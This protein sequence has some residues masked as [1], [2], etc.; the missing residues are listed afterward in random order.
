MWANVLGVLVGALLAL[1]LFGSVLRL[2]WRVAISSPPTETLPQRAR[3]QPFGALPG[4]GSVG[5]LGL[6][7][8]DSGLTGD[9][10]SELLGPGS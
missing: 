7:H 1:L 3:H 6:L 8:P 4:V 2:L 5:S 10:E 9:S